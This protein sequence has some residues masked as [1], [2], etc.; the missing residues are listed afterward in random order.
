MSTWN[1]GLGCYGISQ[2]IV[3]MFNM[4][5]IPHSQ[6][7]YWRKLTDSWQSTQLRTLGWGWPAGVR[8]HP[9]SDIQSLSPQSICGARSPCLFPS[10]W[11]SCSP[12]TLDHA[13]LYLGN[14]SIISVRSHPNSDI[15]SLTPQPI[16]SA[17][18]PCLFPGHQTSCSPSTFDH[19]QL[20][21][22]DPS[23]ISVYPALIADVTGFSIVPPFIFPQ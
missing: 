13:Q 18:S 3:L 17:W 20:Y 7:R 19:A 12:S 16:C 11:T 21:L 14:H 22:G 5:Y 15:R 23:I 8:S 1:C 10:H 6:Q 9:N 4:K 2:H